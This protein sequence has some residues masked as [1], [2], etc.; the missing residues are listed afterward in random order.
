MFISLTHSLFTFTKQKSP[1]LS[2]P[3]GTRFFPV[4]DNCLHSLKEK[5]AAGGPL[6]TKCSSRKRRKGP[7]GPHKSTRIY[8]AGGWVRERG[9]ELNSVLQ[10]VDKRSQGEMVN[11][12]PEGLHEVPLLPWNLPWLERLW[13]HPKFQ[14]C[15]TFPAVLTTD[16]IKN[17]YIFSIMREPKN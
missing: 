12:L 10:K 2:A 16:W 11:S 9:H 15:R 7:E 8:F 14:E 13:N 17:M 3:F 6:D 5:S 4:F 1:A